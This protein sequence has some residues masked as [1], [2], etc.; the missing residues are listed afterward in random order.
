MVT[1]DIFLVCVFLIILFGICLLLF[2]YIYNKIYIKKI[3]E[4]F[5]FF[6]LG[7]EAEKIWLW[8][9]ICF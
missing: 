5:W 9:L 6:S 7:R 2:K 1:N 4:I 3:R 8:L